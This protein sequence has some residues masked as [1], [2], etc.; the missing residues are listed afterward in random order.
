LRELHPDRLV[1]GS[2]RLTVY[3]WWQAELDL[4][5]LLVDEVCP[6]RSLV[7][8]WW[9]ELDE[10]AAMVEESRTWPSRE[11]VALFDERWRRSFNGR[12]GRVPAWAKP[13]RM[14]EGS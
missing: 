14:P 3:P 1:Q 11:F 4:R 8:L 7:Q 13:P 5:P 12:R 10:L 9:R 2:I 6:P